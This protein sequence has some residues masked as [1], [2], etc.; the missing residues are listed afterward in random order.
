MIRY[1]PKKKIRRK[2][3]TSGQSAATAGPP[4]VTQADVDLLREELDGIES[5][6][7][8]R[9]RE[10]KHLELRKQ[11]LESRGPDTK[12]PRRRGP[13]TPKKPLGFTPQNVVSHNDLRIFQLKEQLESGEMTGIEYEKEIGRIR[14][15]LKG[16]LNAGFIDRRYYDSRIADIEGSADKISDYIAIKDYTRIRRTTRKS[17]LRRLWPF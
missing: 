7:D 5:Y 1:I 15:D 3:S 17:G 8:S 13:R 2:R 4:I 12:E 6:I 10:L 9:R 16:R 11:E 14:S